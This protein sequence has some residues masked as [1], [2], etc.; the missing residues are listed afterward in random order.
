MKA[1]ATVSHP[2][3]QKTPVS[4]NQISAENIEGEG[5]AEESTKGGKDLIVSIYGRYTG[6]VECV[7][8]FV[9]QVST[10]PCLFSVFSFL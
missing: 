4:G 3:R 10:R 1:E 2:T 5:G 8:F 9:C 7:V 6:R